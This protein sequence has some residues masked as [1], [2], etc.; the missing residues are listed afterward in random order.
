MFLFRGGEGY[1]P[2]TAYS[3]PIF[4]VLFSLDSL[5]NILAEKELQFEEDKHE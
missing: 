4:Y 5:F 2:M 3:T 1:V